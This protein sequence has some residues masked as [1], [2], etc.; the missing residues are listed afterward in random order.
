MPEEQENSNLISVDPLVNMHVLSESDE[1]GKYL[2][3]RFENFSLKESEK[4]EL[5]KVVESTHI[6]ELYNHGLL[7]TN[8]I[9]DTEIVLKP[10]QMRTF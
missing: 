5:M 2:V 6:S 10:M 8:Q 9:T 7:K 1:N 4:I 3:V